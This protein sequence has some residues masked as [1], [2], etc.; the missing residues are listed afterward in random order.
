MLNKTRIQKFRVFSGDF[1]YCHTCQ[2]TRSQGRIRENPSNCPRPG[3]VTISVQMPPVHGWYGCPWR[4]REYPFNCPCQW[5][6][7]QGRIRSSHQIVPA[8]AGSHLASKCSRVQG[9]NGCP[10]ILWRSFCGG[11]GHKS[12]SRR[13]VRARYESERLPSRYIRLVEEWRG[14]FRWG[15]R[16]AQ[17]RKVSLVRH[18]GLNYHV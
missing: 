2:W 14:G 15:G 18:H 12:V 3:W 7:S 8:P 16:I 13:S 4:I 9:S 17:Q 11:H 10:C 5:T 1:S 6:R